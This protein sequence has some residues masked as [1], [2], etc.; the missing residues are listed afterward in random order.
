MVACLLIAVLWTAV[1]AVIFPFYAAWTIFDTTAF[2]GRA[3]ATAQGSVVSSTQHVFVGTGPGQ[4]TTVSCDN[5][6]TF[7]TTAGRSITFV[8]K[9]GSC[10]NATL[11]V[12]YD[13]SHPSDARASG[14]AHAVLIGAYIIDG[15]YLF[16]LLIIAYYAIKGWWHK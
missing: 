3:T 12:L 16:L 6:I 10:N 11:T 9:G 15:I 4:A 14:S 7:Q 8:E 5:T 2:L 1:V 13:P